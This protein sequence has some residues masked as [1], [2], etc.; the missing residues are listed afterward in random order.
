M[1]VLN[2]S[3]GWEVHFGRA[4]SVR[5]EGLSLSSSTHMNSQA[6][7]LASLRQRQADPQLAS[8]PATTASARFSETLSENV[9]WEMNREDIWL[10]PYIGEYRV[11]STT[12]FT[13]ISHTHMHHTHH[14][15]ALCTCISH[16][17]YTHASHTCI[18]HMH[19]THASQCIA[20]MHHT[21]VLHACISHRHHTNIHMQHTHHTHASHTHTAGG[22]PPLLQ[23]SIV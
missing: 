11:H 22:K 9:T 15:H 12:K 23:W 7:P 2:F 5:C 8:Q 3:K 14:R 21:H 16:M 1:S 13:C 6:W 20:H 17:H 10:L 4:S 18:T 19:Y